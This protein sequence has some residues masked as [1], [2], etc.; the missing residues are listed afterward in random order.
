MSCSRI[1]NLI[2]DRIPEILPNIRPKTFIQ[3]KYSVG[4][5][6]HHQLGS[7]DKKTKDLMKKDLK[8]KDLVDNRPNWTK[9]PNDKRPDRKKDIIGPKT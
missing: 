9:Q 6:N 5:P 7:W 4:Y 2:S 1:L 8:A 3:P